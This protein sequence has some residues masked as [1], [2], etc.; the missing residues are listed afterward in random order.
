MIQVLAVASAGALLQLVALQPVPM[1]L[2]I[3][4]KLPVVAALQQPAATA[5]LNQTPSDTVLADGAPLIEVQ[6]MLLRAKTATRTVTN[7][8]AVPRTN[9][10]PLTVLPMPVLLDTVVHLLLVAEL[11][12]LALLAI[13][14]EEA[15]PKDLLLLVEAVM[16]RLAVLAMLMRAPS[17]LVDTPKVMPLVESQTVSV[18]VP[19]LLVLALLETLAALLT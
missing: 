9:T 5:T 8:V 12:L 15:L 10:V 11:V 13:L 16:L 1:H 3:L 17:V 7:M 4:E 2:V 18:A 14:L 19:D 6:L